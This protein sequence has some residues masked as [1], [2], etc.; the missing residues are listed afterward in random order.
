MKPIRALMIGV[1]LGFVITVGAETVIDDAALADEADAVNWPGYG[2]TYSEQRFSP[3][4][5]INASN[6]RKLGV[7]WVLDLPKDQN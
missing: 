7:E 2:R 1:G 3:L 5:Q 4:D 6:V